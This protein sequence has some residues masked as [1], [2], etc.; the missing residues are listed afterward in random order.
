MW[1]CVKPGT[2]FLNLALDIFNLSMKRLQTDLTTSAIRFAVP[3][4]YGIKVILRM[5]RY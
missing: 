1:Q 5:L 4:G 3:W 2:N